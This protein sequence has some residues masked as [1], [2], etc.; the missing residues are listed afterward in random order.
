LHVSR[1]VDSA[2]VAR[3]ISEA[4]SANQIKNR[5]IVDIFSFG[6]LPTGQHFYV[7]DLLDGA[8]LDQY[9]K[10]KTQLTPEVALPLLRPVA[11][12]LD[13][14]HAHGIIHRDVKP[15]NIFLAWESNNEVVP[16]LLDF[17]L[18]K[19]LSDS[20]IHT[21][22]GVPMGT[23]YYMSPEQ[24]RGEKVDARAD[25]YSFGVICHELMAG[26]PPFT[27]DTPA[28]VL[29]SHLVK[30]PP[31]LSEV[32]PELPS[33][34]DAPILHM[35]AKDPADR[36]SSVGAAFAE[37]EEAAR[38]AGINV[39]AGFPHL[40]RPTLPAPADPALSYVGVA[41]GGLPLSEVGSRKGLRQAFLAGGLLV[42]LAGGGLYS[43][44][45]KGPSDGA[46]L[47]SAADAGG[48]MSS[49]PVLSVA[50]PEPS[51]AKVPEKQKAELTL[52]GVPDGTRVLLGDEL[53]GETPAKV[54]LR[55]GSD[56][57]ELTLSARGYENKTVRV[58]PN[59]AVELTVTL[60]KPAVRAPQPKRVSKDLENP[61]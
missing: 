11:M 3:F 15:P 34:L 56:P 9:L 36:P 1:T 2:A 59:G 10:E 42:L 43:L 8:P 30:P 7:M 61:F 47:A 38:A 40:P 23:P 20:P 37:L 16:K 18:V 33:A 29:V 52:N 55:F 32:C 12:A 53:L 19:L 51:F 44:L 28:A 5:H 57:L 41:D 4:Q 60:V 58:V 35:L 27:G 26:Q 25:V 24:C 31:K 13:A 17:G 46:A 45:G 14:L 50:P 6:K 21:A 39:E 22:S 54:P 49:A 48:L